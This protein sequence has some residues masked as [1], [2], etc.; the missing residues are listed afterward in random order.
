MAVP[1]PFKVRK[2]RV[3]IVTVFLL[4]ISTACLF[5]IFF[6]YSR[7]YRGIVDLSDAM[8][9]ET[10]DDL[11]LKIDNIT[12][13]AKLLSELTKGALSNTDPNTALHNNLV[14]FLINALKND[15]MVYSIN[16]ALENSSFIST[17]NLSLANI[18]TYYSKPEQSLPQGSK[19]AVRIIDQQQTP[20]SETWQ[21]LGTD[22]SVLASETVS[23]ISYDPKTDSWFT[24]MQKWPSIQWSN[25]YLPRGLAKQI[26]GGEPG[27]TVS[28]PVTDSEGKFKAVIGINLSLKFLSNFITHQRIGVTGKAFVLDSQGSLL[29]P[30]PNNLDSASKGIAQNIIAPAFQQ[31]TL[32]RQTHFLMEYE[33][34]RYIVYISNFPI[35]L[36]Q[37]WSIAVAVPFEDFFGQTIKTQHQTIL[38]CL[39][40]LVLFAIFVFYSSKHISKPIVEL[41]HEVDKIRHFDFE[42][43]IK[44]KTH[45]QEIMTLD[46]SITAMRAALHSF[47][48]Y[49]PKEIVRSLVEQGREIVLGGE[50]RT[51]TI[52]FTDIKDF[53]SSSEA[54]PVETLM[55]SLAEYFD[56]LSKIILETE[57]TID[58]FI[59]DSIMAFWG[60]PKIVDEQANKACLAALRCRKACRQLLKENG[61]EKWYTRFGIHAGEVIVGNIGTAERMNYTAIGDSVNIAS[62][63]EGINKAYQTS[64]TISQT[65]KESLDASFVTRPLD[66]V[67]VKGKKQKLEIYELVG[68]QKEVE[69]AP[70][71]AEIELCRAF[72]EA[73]NAFYAGKMEEAKKLFLQIQQR[74]PAD[75]PT[76]I[77]L[78]RIQ[79]ANQL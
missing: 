49:V 51:I 22:M 45:I 74:Y 53:T 5:T 7:N 68:M 69:V 66:I 34:V 67:A 38:I 63:L 1:N 20:P 30:A 24:D 62:R 3:D 17:I 40:I 37:K 6:T 55:S 21:Y 25:T 11:V 75:A 76:R 70:T 58:K 73:Y 78:E 16:V 44:I 9:H 50:K 65:V 32:S 29:V 72:T 64:I 8:I 57:G 59:G 4:L 18:T 27:I 31:F 14:S 52:M 42:N 77:Y 15:Q 35:S 48:R 47:G 79:A 71:P 39:A 36:A 43:P 46:S 26:T 13:Q 41:A 28:A 12:D 19:Y 60:A 54:M 2:I 23:P 10:S 56:L 33:K 61:E